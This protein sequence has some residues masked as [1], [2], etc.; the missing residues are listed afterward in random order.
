MINGERKQLLE[1]CP[2]YQLANNKSGDFSDRGNYSKPKIKKRFLYLFEDSLIVAS[3]NR[4]KFEVIKQYKTAELTIFP[5]EN[6]K[7]K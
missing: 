4:A 6:G 7:K 5:V 1:V 3:R 2:A